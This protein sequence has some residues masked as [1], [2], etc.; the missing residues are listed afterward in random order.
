MQPKPCPKCANGKEKCCDECCEWEV[1]SKKTKLPED[2]KRQ[3]TKEA[4]LGQLMNASVGGN[5]KKMKPTAL[6]SGPISSKPFPQQQLGEQNNNR[7]LQ[8]THLLRNSTD[9][10][11]Q[12]SASTFDVS[13]YLSST[14]VKNLLP[15]ARMYSDHFYTKLASLESML[16]KTL[17]GIF[18]AIPQQYRQ[19]ITSAV[20]DKLYPVASSSAFSEGVKNLGSL[21]SDLGSRMRGAITAPGTISR[22]SMLRGAPASQPQQAAVPQQSV[23]PPKAIPTGKSRPASDF[24]KQLAARSSPK[25]L[26]TTPSGDV[27]TPKAYKNNAQLMAASAQSDLRGRYS[28]AGLGE[29]DVNLPPAELTKRIANYIAVNRANDLSGLPAH[30]QQSYEA[31]PDNVKENIGRT[32]RGNIITNALTRPDNPYQPAFTDK[33]IDDAVLSAAD[34]LN[35]ITNTL[36]IVPSAVGLTDKQKTFS[37]IDEMRGMVAGSKSIDDLNKMIAETDTKIR[38][39]AANGISNPADQSKLNRYVLAKQYVLRGMSVTDLNKKDYIPLFNP[40]MGKGEKALETLS[41]ALGTLWPGMTA[42]RSVSRF[43]LNANDVSNADAKADL[44][45]LLMPTSPGNTAK[46]IRAMLSPRDTLRRASDS[47]TK[48]VRDFSASSPA[49]KALQIA[50]APITAPMKVL[51]N[52]LA[53][54]GGLGLAMYNDISK[55][56]PQS[57][58][59]RVY[60]DAVNAANAGIN[61]YESQ[62]NLNND[63]SNLIKYLLYAGLSV[64]AIMAIMS[65]MGGQG[66]EESPE[67]AQT[68]EEAPGVTYAKA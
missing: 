60:T 22:L 17:P 10:S 40:E 57:A 11:I 34:P 16:T 46:G 6:S 32:L 30:H 67:E 39:D 19:P 15:K 56:S 4:A 26:P 41:D 42:A 62:G 7:F 43:G 47:I 45:G 23:A 58:S 29:Q 65:S 54:K 55:A 27:S 3:T 68:A 28:K 18:Q 44:I 31:L 21:F 8:Q 13:P 52:E 66:D 48:S 49:S 64:P 12:K 1:A 36:K 33:S 14:Y 59:S 53:T 63:K 5:Q 20:Q 24:Q 25:Q 9:G 35:S 2:V 38:R 61:N 51:N 50:K 37:N